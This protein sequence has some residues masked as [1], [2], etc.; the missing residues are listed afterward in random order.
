MQHRTYNKNNIAL[1]YNTHKTGTLLNNMAIQHIIQHA[2]N[3]NKF[4]KHG[5]TTRK[6][7]IK[8]EIKTR[9]C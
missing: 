9:F 2:Y 7:K 8:R 5:N 3:M 4:I 1:K 6:S